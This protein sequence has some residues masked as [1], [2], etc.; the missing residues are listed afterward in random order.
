M[1][2]TGVKSWSQT[3]ANNASY[4]S[5][6]NF[7]EGQAPSTINDSCRALMASVAKYRDDI[8]GATVTG[9]GGNV[10]TLATYQVFQSLTEMNGQMVAFTASFTNTGAC[11]LNVDS[12]GN[13]TIRSAPGVDLPSGTLISGSTYAAIYNNSDGIFY[14]HGF[15]GSSFYVPVGAL[16]DFAGSSAPNSNFALAYGQAISRT[17]YATLFSLLGTTYGTG[18]GTT[19]FNIPDLRGRV[20]AGKDDM[21][22]SAAGRLTSF[23]ITGGATGL[24][25][26]GGAEGIT[27]TASTLPSLSI[28]GSTSG[29]MSVSGSTG[30]NVVLSGSGAGGV[31]GGGSFGPSGSASISGTASGSL[32]VSGSVSGTGGAAHGNTQPTFIL[33]KLM[34]IL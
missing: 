34:R 9:G 5:T 28:T 25:N 19:T 15:Y 18:D 10:Y 4:D 27:L 14:L 17:T 21:G 12:L 30:S 6:V 22:G 26:A 16:V 13:K 7:L 33:N 31:G 24:G 11:A 2:S 1:A 8:A 20:V 32:S 29:S 23:T 3:A